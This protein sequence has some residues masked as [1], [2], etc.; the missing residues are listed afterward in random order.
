MHYEVTGDSATGVD[1]PE[2]I[3]TP[4][5][6]NILS[7]THA[8]SAIRAFFAAEKPSE[9]EP[10]DVCTVV[11]M[12]AR[13]SEDHPIHDS[14]LTLAQAFGADSKTVKRSQQRLEKLGWLSRPQRRG[15]SN[16]LSLNYETLP[17]ADPQYTQVGPEAKQFASRYQQHMVRL[18]IR[19][20]FPKA[21]LSAQ[22]ISA[23]RILNACDGD[24]TRAWGLVEFVLSD[25]H[26]KRKAM[27]SL[28]TVRQSWKRITTAFEAGQSSPPMRPLLV[29]RHEQHPQAEATVE[30]IRGRA[31]LPLS[32]APLWH[33]V[34]DGLLSDGFSQASI[35]DGIAELAK[36][37]EGRTTLQTSDPQGF[38]GGSRD[39]WQVR[40]GESHEY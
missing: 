15:K 18:G 5:T 40:K 33:P 3:T 20:R 8:I 7:D 17:F 31:G 27:K 37:N 34:V 24:V 10:I 26:L 16:A 35:L 36:T 30:R 29:R 19:K 39:G 1:A 28:Y 12:L 13:K 38:R 25:E 11:Y 22:H 6:T 21:W 23:Q 9:L 4:R 32:H 2:T 14:Q